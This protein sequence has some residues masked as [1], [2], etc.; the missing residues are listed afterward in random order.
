MSRATLRTRSGSL[1]VI[2]LWVVTILSVLAVAIARYLAVEVR[3]AKYRLAREQAKALAC[4]GIYLVMQQ[5]AHDAD[6]QNVPQPYEAYDW[7]GDDWA[8]PR[9]DLHVAGGRIT[10]RSVVDEE[11]LLNLN[12]ATQE[13][14]ESLA[15]SSPAATAILAY[16]DAN[17]SGETPVDEP[18]YY[19][20]NTPIKAME[21]LAD[22]PDIHDTDLAKLQQLTS[23]ST[24][25][26]M[27]PTVNINTVEG[28]VLIALGWPKAVVDPLVASRPGA[29]GVWGTP[30]DRKITDATITDPAQ[31]LER[32]TGIPAATW[33]PLLTTIKTVASSS[34]FR[35]Q[36]EATA[37][38]PPVRQRI[39]AIVKR[40]PDGGEI[41]AWR[42]Q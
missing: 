29:D 34:V 22:I 23:V 7:L 16:R 5:L 6:P 30:D 41:L 32:F 9:E 20:K 38:S 25:A 12:A 1:L 31:E 4:S 18:P 15:G 37:G 35:I 39:D 42:E 40:A 36:V 17:T 24:D 13:Q 28:D 19:Q 3:L 26:V 8:L 2:T 10:V 14:L 11:R 21:E 33:N 27:P